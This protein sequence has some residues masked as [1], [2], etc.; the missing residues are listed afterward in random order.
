MTTE[1]MNDFV[2]IVS[3]EGLLQQY[4]IAEDFIE[5]DIRQ[6]KIIQEQKP[7]WNEWISN[8]S[9]DGNRYTYPSRNLGRDMGIMIHKID[10]NRNLMSI[11]KE[12]IKEKCLLLGLNSEEIIKAKQI[13]RIP[14]LEF[15]PEYKE[16]IGEPTR[17]RRCV[18]AF[19][20]KYSEIK[21]QY[22]S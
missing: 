22:Y 9:Y 6:I 18:D 15:L 14:S 11:K 10:K 12:K 21:H 16:F 17:K 5:R 1:T 19:G 7:S 13:P 20:Q 8:I 4:K 2:N 3:L